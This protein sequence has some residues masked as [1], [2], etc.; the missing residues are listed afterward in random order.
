[1]DSRPM[2]TF[3]R[4]R[5]PGH[6]RITPYSGR[7]NFLVAIPDRLRNLLSPPFD[8]VAAAAASVPFMAT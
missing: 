6:R 2:G 4:V 1:M 5:L 3:G 8:S 7:A